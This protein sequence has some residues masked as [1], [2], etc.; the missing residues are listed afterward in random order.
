MRF[1]ADSNSIWV[2]ETTALSILHFLALENLRDANI[3]FDNLKQVLKSVEGFAVNV[4]PLFDE[5]AAFV[6]PNRFLV[7]A[8][9]H[10]RA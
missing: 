7:E 2:E 6:P 4:N 1:A 9:T 3:L 5:G 10:L 8:S